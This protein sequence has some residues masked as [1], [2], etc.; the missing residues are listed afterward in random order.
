MWSGGRLL[1]DDLYLVRAASAF[2]AARV[3]QGS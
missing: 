3:F 1:A 2:D